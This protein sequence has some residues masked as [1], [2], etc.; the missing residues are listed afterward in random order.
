MRRFSAVARRAK[1]EFGTPPRRV[2]EREYCKGFST[3]PR[4]E[5]GELLLLV[6]YPE[7]RTPWS[8]RR[9]WFDRTTIK[10]LVCSFLI[11][12][13]VLLA[14]NFS[15]VLHVKFCGR[16][17]CLKFCYKISKT[18]KKLELLFR[19]NFLLRENFLQFTPPLV[20]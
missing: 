17:N 4:G 19:V 8:G 6:K 18:T 1:I 20:V 11:V 2:G 5:K 14:F 12:I 9:S 13:Y 15:Y 10:I 3:L 16:K 7:R